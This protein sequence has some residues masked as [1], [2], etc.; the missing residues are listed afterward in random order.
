[1]K[2]GN[3]RIRS[4]K[5]FFIL[6]ES[7]GTVKLGYRARKKIQLEFSVNWVYC[8]YKIVIFLITLPIIQTGSGTRSSHHTHTRTDTQTHRHTHTYTHKV[9]PVAKSTI[10]ICFNSVLP[11][12]KNIDLMLLLVELFESESFNRCKICTMGYCSV[13]LW[14]AADVLNERRVS[15]QSRSFLLVGLVF[16]QRFPGAV[17][18]RQYSQLLLKKC[19]WCAGL[20]FDLKWQFPRKDVVRFPWKHGKTTEA[21][22]TTAA[23]YYE[24]PNKIQTL[25]PEPGLRVKRQQR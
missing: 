9:E 3:T 25:L 19:L 1:M 15:R 23:K 7:S 12:E 16:V 14:E 8:I 13:C 5:D 10:G 6:S 11:V 17:K 18:M 21:V 2:L 4:T 22:S 24:S 20:W